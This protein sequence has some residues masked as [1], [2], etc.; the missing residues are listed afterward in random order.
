M[1]TERAPSGSLPASYFEA[2]HR[3][4]IDPWDFRTSVYERHKF[5]AT[6]AALTQPRYR[7]G[8][9]AG[10][11]IGVLSAHLAERCDHLIA[12][13]A[14]PT[15]IA[16]AAR[17]NLPHVRFETAVLPDAFPIGRFDLIVL[18]ELLYYFGE[19]DLTCLANKC[20][21]AMKVGGEMILCHWLGETNYPLSGRQASDLF[22]KA[23][24]THRPVR[25]VLHDDIYRLERLFF[26][27]DVAG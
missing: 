9:E 24:A 21:D 5:H 1:S 6:T 15:A 18:S 19:D 8:F 23:V 13:D 10:C 12:V 16:E 22:V 7:R 27:A 3:A 4:N 11:G 25:V 20:V 26:A 2:K 14:S 17:Q